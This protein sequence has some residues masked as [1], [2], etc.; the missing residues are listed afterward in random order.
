MNITVDDSVLR[1]RLRKLLNKLKNKKPLL[2]SIG[3]TVQN[4]IEAHFSNQVGPGGIAWRALA[5]STLKRRRTS[6]S[7]G[8]A[9]PKILQDKGE[10]SN[11]GF[12][13]FNDYVLIGTLQ[14]ET[15]SGYNYG[16]AHQ[17]GS[18]VPKRE[19]LYI[20][21]SGEKKIDKVVHYYLKEK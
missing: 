19:W 9:I 16:K 5:A 12:E 7:R 15:S 3:V 18:G 2:A 8:S 11:I 10:L 1:Y 4:D 21:N 6:A 20:S 17:K 13:L 14:G